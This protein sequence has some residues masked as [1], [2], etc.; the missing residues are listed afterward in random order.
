MLSTYMMCA[1]ENID[2]SESD[3]TFTF[4]S[5]LCQLHHPDIIL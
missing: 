3:A 4:W 5:I 1:L 2:F